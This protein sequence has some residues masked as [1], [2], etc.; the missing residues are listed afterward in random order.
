MKKDNH[1]ENRAKRHKE[2]QEMI[3]LG[4]PMSI[5]SKTTGLLP[6]EILSYRNT[7]DNQASEM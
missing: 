5:V 6:K 2:A 3:E 4:V 7:S 1:L